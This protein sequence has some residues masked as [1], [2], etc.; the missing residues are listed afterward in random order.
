MVRLFVAAWIAASVFLGGTTPV[1]AKSQTYLTTEG[2]A[3]MMAAKGLKAQWN[4]AR[5]ICLEQGY[6]LG[7]E[8]FLN[9]FAEYTL[10]SLRGLRT[11]AKGLTDDVAKKHGLCIDRKRF[12]I[13]RCEEI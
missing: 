13:G 12:E 1:Q 10:F 11:R 4:V 7:T 2:T 8:Q 5:L 9:C 6:K 3:R